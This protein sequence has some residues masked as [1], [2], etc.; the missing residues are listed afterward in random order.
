MSKPLSTQPFQ[1]DVFLADEADQWFARNKSVL[2]L[3]RDDLVINS[4]SLVVSKPRRIL[5]IGCANG[6]RLDRLH[7]LYAAECVGIDPSGKAV[8]QGREIFPALDL[9]VGSADA[10][11]DID[12]QF[13]VVIFGFCFYLIDP[14]L[15][16]R[17]VAE[18]DRVLSDN[19]ILVISDFL[20]PIPYHNVYSHR[21]G[22]RSYKL[23]FCRYFLAHPAY[24]LIHR[25]LNHQKSDLFNPDHREGV[26]ILIKS[27]SNAFPA[28]PFQVKP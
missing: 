26:D 6:W 3:E 7:Q 4:L 28:N 11:P 1:R 19:G 17:C 5:E 14:V 18:A 25:T 22:V 16:F 20:T 21:E 15:H 12:G 2:A 23:E 24:N 13:D 10:I 8:A 9:R 27:L